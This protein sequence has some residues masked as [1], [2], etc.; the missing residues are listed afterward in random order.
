VSDDDA[1]EE[2]AL[3]RGKEGRAPGF[4]SGFL[5]DDEEEEKE[6]YRDHPE[7]SG[8]TI[9][10]PHHARDDSADQPPR[11]AGTSDTS[12]DGSWVDAR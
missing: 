2:D 7:G 8:V 5:E 9:T 10:A 3:V 6:R 12:G 11:E 4:H 1:D